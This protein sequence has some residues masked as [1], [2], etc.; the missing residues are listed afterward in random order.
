GQRMPEGENRQNPQLNANGQQ[1]NAARNNEAG[2]PKT[3][4]PNAPQDRQPSQGNPSET[5]RARKSGTD[6][7]AG[8]NPKEPNP[9]PENLRT[10]DQSD[11][12]RGKVPNADQQDM[13]RDLASGT[14]PKD[15]K[16]AAAER[17]QGQGGERRQS[18]DAATKT[19]D[20]QAQGR[21]T[22][23]EAVRDTTGQKP[24]EARPDKYA[25]EEKEK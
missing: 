3:D 2:T 1:S 12:Q 21:K 25:T 13:N 10:K 7:T 11:I 24:K 18:P 6:S 8:S 17:Q 14:T 16:P 22:N 19:K 9:N 23:Q 4:S 5:E 20:A 15:Q